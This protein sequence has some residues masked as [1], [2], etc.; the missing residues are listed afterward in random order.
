L[1]RAIL[2]NKAKK[3]RTDPRK[4]IGYQILQGLFSVCAVY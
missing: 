4:Q 3:K 1:E 2:T